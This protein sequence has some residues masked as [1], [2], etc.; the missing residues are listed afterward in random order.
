MLT[1]VNRQHKGFGQLNQSTSL[2]STLNSGLNT[3]INISSA[4]GAGSYQHYG[5]NALGEL[6]LPCRILKKFRYLFENAIFF[7]SPYCIRMI[8]SGSTIYLLLNSRPPPNYLLIFNVCP[9]FCHH[10]FVFVNQ[11]TYFV[12]LTCNVFLSHANL[13]R[14]L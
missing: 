9:N 12:C 7:S 1:F 14:L 13:L 5:L 2:S 6:E 4:M 10:H 11:S 8:F 3:G